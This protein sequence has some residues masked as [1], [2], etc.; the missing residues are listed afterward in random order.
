MSDQFDRFGEGE[1]C[2]LLGLS[3]VALCDLMEKQSVGEEHCHQQ[4]R[5]WLC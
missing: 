3:F 1:V 2:T 5:P 4:D